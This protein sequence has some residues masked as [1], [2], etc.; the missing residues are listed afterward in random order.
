MLVPAIQRARD[1][2]RAVECKN[3]LKQTMLALHV[4]HDTNETFPPGYIAITGIQGETQENNWAWGAFLLPYIEQNALFASINFEAGL[5]AGASQEFDQRNAG[6]VPT[7]NLTVISTVINTAT[8][9]VDQTPETLSR[10]DSAL[11]SVEYAASSYAGMSGIHWMDLPCATIVE[12]PGENLPEL[13]APP[14]QSSEGVFYLNSRIR[15]QDLTDGTSA[16]IGIGE[17]SWRFDHIGGS[18]ARSNGNFAGGSQLMRVTDAL[19]PEHVL[20]ATSQGIND[21]DHQGF[22]PGLSSYHIGGAHV[23]LMDGSIRFVA[24]SIESNPRSPYGL[25]QK[26]STIRGHE[27][28][29]EF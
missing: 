23:G 2:A 10:N 5:S 16:T 18:P 22:S 25:L 12:K 6:S 17:V 3:R 20:T 14:C 27:P 29:T 9:P 19:S 24:D 7:T 26:L 28:V 15:F 4:Y 13:T 21:P 1:A 8:C 11:G